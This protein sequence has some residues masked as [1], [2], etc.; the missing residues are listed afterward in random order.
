MLKRS[1]REDYMKT[2]QGPV[3]TKLKLKRIN[4]NPTEKVNVRFQRNE[5]LKRNKLLQFL[6]CQDLMA[7]I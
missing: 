6:L 1:N 3:L 4:Q 2:K 5:K 7:S